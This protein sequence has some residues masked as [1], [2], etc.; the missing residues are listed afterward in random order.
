[1][2]QTIEPATQ[3]NTSSFEDFLIK[4]IDTDKLDTYMG[5]LQSSHSIVST[6]A[7]LSGMKPIPNLKTLENIIASSS[8]GHFS[9]EDKIK[10]CHFKDHLLEYILYVFGHYKHTFE[11]DGVNIFEKYCHRPKEGIQNPKTIE[12][13][14][15]DLI[16]PEFKLTA[17]RIRKIYK[18]ITKY[19]IGFDDLSDSSVR[20]ALK[21]T[22]IRTT[23]RLIFFLGELTEIDER[24]TPW[25][26]RKRQVGTY[27]G[28]K[29]TKRKRI[30]K[31][32]TQKKRASRLSSSL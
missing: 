15:F 25:F 5:W 21:D 17:K 31:T 2:S 28:G 1:M 24:P 26:S 3:E 12:S 7:S 19:I 30:R 20:E 32:I 6:V 18:I 4:W 11:Q 13:A 22:N 14:E 8:P 9:E 29:Y 27:G 16:P 10:Y 23:H